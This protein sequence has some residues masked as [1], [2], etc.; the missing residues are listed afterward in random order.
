[1]TFNEFKMCCILFCKTFEGRKYGDVVKSCH[2]VDRRLII[3]KHPKFIQCDFLLCG[4]FVWRF[5]NLGILHINTDDYEILIHLLTV[6]DFLNY[7]K[8]YLEDII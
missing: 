1:M 4:S 3:P 7:F 2:V 5:L 6:E 8:I